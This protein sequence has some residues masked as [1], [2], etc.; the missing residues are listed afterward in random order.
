MRN[1]QGKR[2]SKR[3]LLALLVIVAMLTP[4]FSAIAL[5]ED[6]LEQYGEVEFELEV[7]SPEDDY[8]DYDDDY[9]DAPVYDD[10]DDEDEYEVVVDD[11]EDESVVEADDLSGDILEAAADD[12]TVGEDLVIYDLDEPDKEY[13]E[14]IEKP[15]VA[16]VLSVLPTTLTATLSNGERTDVSV[17][18][19][20]EDEE[21]FEDGEYGAFP[22]VAALGKDCKYEADEDEMEDNYP[23][24][25]IF[26]RYISELAASGEAVYMVTAKP[27]EKAA[28]VAAAM[29]W[30]DTVTATLEGYETSETRQ[31]AVTWVCDDYDEADEGDFMFIAQLEDDLG[32]LL[33]SDVEM[34]DKQL[35]VLQNDEFEFIINEKDQTVTITGWKASGD[36]L[37]VPSDIS[38]YP[39]VDIA[40]R[41]FADYPD[42][43]DVTIANGVTALG[44]GVFANCGSLRWVT[45]PD[46]LETVPGDVFD[47]ASDDL[48]ITLDVKD[49][50]VLSAPNTYR[51]GE[52]TV[53]LPKDIASLTVSGSVTV[54]TDFTIEDDDNF[55]YIDVQGGAL[56]LTEGHVIVN[57]NML[58]NSGTVVNN[59]KIYGCYSSSEKTGDVAGY[60]TEHTD[61][62]S[63]G[64]C[65]ICGEAIGKEGR[66]LTVTVNK[67]LPITKVY[68]GTRAIGTALTKDDFTLG[69]VDAADTVTITGIAG[70]TFNQEDAGT[71]TITVYLQIDQTSEKY[72][73]YVEGG[74]YT[75]EKAEITPV[76]L[77][78]ENVEDIADQVYDG[79]DVEPEVTVKVGT[80]T[81]KADED[82]FVTYADN[83]KVGTARATV[84]GFGNYEGEVTKEFKI[85]AGKA[86][87]KVS[88]NMKNDAKLTK[89]YDAT[90]AAPLTVDDFAVK[91]DTVGA[92]DTVTIEKIEATYDDANAGENK[93]VTVKFTLASDSAAYDYV[94]D[95]MELAGA[96][97][98]ARS[99]TDSAVTQ[100]PANIETQ[101]HTGSAVKPA[102]TLKLGTKTLVQDR[103]Y[104]VTYANNVNAGT[105]TMTITGKGNFT[106][107][108]TNTFKISDSGKTT[109]AVTIEIIS[110]HEPSKIYDK[111]VNVSL[112]PSDFNISGVA[113][114]DSVKIVGIKAA[115]NSSSVGTDKTVKVSF[116]LSQSSTQYNYKADDITIEKCEIEKRTLVIY[117]AKGQSKIYGTADPS[118]FKG[119]ERGL[120]SGDTVTG[121]LSRD[122]GEDVEEDGYAYD[123]GTLKVN[124]DN[125]NYEVEI[126]DNDAVFMIN[127][128]PISAADVTVTLDKTE[129]TED[130]DGVE[131]EITVKYGTKTLE[132]DDDYEVAFSN[133]TKHGTGLATLTG[134][135]NYTGTRTVSFKIKKDHSG[136][137][138]G[139]SGSSSSDDEEDEDEMDD[140][141]AEIGELIIDFDDKRVPVGYILFGEDNRP[142]PFEYEKPEITPE[143]AQVFPL[144]DTMATDPQGNPITYMRLVITPEPVRDTDDIPLSMTSD[145]SRDKYEDL[146]LRLTPTQIETLK[147][148]HFVEVVYQ[149]ES[150]ELRVPLDQLTNEIDLAPFTPKDEPKPE[151]AYADAEDA[152]VEA[153]G[154][155]EAEDG[156]TLEDI[157]ADDMPDAMDGDPALAADDLPIAPE[158]ARVSNYV[159]SIKQ[160]ETDD[161]TE[162]ET[163]ALEG[164][165][166]LVPM[167]RVDLSA[168]NGTLE[169]VLTPNAPGVV[170]AQAEETPEDA[171]GIEDIDATPDPLK[172]AP[173]F[174][175]M[176]DKLENLE[177]R[178]YSDLTLPDEELV[179]E[180]P[181]DARGIVIV[182][183][184]SV[185]DE[186]AVET[187]LVQYLEDTSD[188]TQYQY[189][190]RFPAGKSGLYTIVM[191]ALEDEDEDGEY[192]D[193]EDYVDDEEYID[194]EEPAEDEENVDDEEDF[195][196][197][198]VTDDEQF[199][200]EDTGDEEAE[201]EFIEDEPEEDLIEEEPAEEEIVEE[202][203]AEE[204]P[205]EEAEEAEP[206]EE[207]AEEEPEVEIIPDPDPAYAY[208]RK[209]NAGDQYWLINTQEQTVEYFRADTNEYLIGD[210]TG[211]LMSG[212][213]VTFREPERA[214]TIQLKFQQTYKF[215][216][217]DD[218]GVSLLMEQDKTDEVEEIMKPHRQ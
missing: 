58:I 141:E 216:M 70:T 202:A 132:E 152:D 137:S 209:S 89:V 192:E 71:T 65:D 128:K 146:Q 196:D 134:I 27:A 68:D 142:R 7:E 136:S 91:A 149:L 205:V 80:K 28:D 57:K 218:E 133:N 95:D 214:T 106:G 69:N 54:D 188:D 113:D 109:K 77:T 55:N 197:D 148:E 108:R 161:L 162:R 124:G 98:T 114:G 39:V 154:E 130:S 47:G 156:E 103:D 168:V 74:Q 36:V 210:Y 110:G 99:I 90:D 72:N 138:G 104:T 159:F 3:G 107:T 185:A 40:N 121:S 175:S 163:A 208:S 182:E 193:D 17:T 115:Y 187:E 203:P 42:L 67:T 144:A 207:A 140:R 170:P 56:T 48:A 112:K 199:E 75:I 217:M 61:A 204:E 117:P 172:P 52:A 73:Y 147:A 9:D 181:E 92:G 81:L 85:L 131:P 169:T 184:A 171:E 63:D 59:G 51:R 119:T 212:M 1:D 29:G 11:Y 101:K 145:E 167:Y 44:N 24:V 150:A 166:S 8:D 153:D 123:V 213:Q 178:V 16:Q 198:A 37:N 111:T 26:V 46:S 177:I 50:I 96:S 129:Y 84:E 5:A 32:Y 180:L 12:L 23:V 94:A 194:D 6:D 45:L 125:G 14:V 34:P 60:I 22:F 206:V 4:M 164:Y 83:D 49:D 18:W 127:P 53:K 189:Y 151:T 20:P 179:N 86:E 201:E 100:T 76:K 102:V 66:K 30:P 174:Y 93:V 88:V 21:D 165:A 15:T 183:D 122:E 38:G 105:A 186:D 79:E 116:E 155:A 158:M 13:Y 19:A 160:I 200:A 62:D 215:A 191:E 195:E 176:L 2:G 135:G 157:D 143:E 33:G 120:L 25:T 10:D 97:I 41:A 78:L 31:V 87:K 82:Y 126:A 35:S 43:A 173:V 139:S 64:T 118:Y 211:S 190:T